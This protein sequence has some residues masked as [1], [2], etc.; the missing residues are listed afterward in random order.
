MAGWQAGYSEGTATVVLER[1]QWVDAQR[2]HCLLIPTTPMKLE[3][4]AF[5]VCC[6][7]LSP[8]RMKKKTQ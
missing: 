6:C 3:C 5:S 7:L 2:H 1:M 8:P 4:V